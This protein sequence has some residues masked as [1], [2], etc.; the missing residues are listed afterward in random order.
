MAGNNVWVKSGTVRNMYAEPGVLVTG[1]SAGRYKDSPKATFQATVTGTGAVSATVTIEYSNDN[2]NWCSTVGGT[3]TLSG[4]TSS[5]DGFTSD[6]PWK[7][8]RA[9]V[10]A[11]SGTNATV[12]VYAGV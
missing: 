7:Y 8:C 10:T 1:P 4:T 6:S 9:N 5:S 12:Q 3:V 11:I 2:V